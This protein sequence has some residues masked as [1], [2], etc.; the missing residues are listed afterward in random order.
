MILCWFRLFCGKKDVIP[1]FFK[2]TQLFVV[3]IYFFH[4]FYKDATLSPGYPPG[5]LMLPN[6]TNQFIELSDRDLQCEWNS[7]I[8]IKYFEHLTRNSKRT[9]NYV[10]ILY[11]KFKNSTR[12]DYFLNLQVFWHTFF[13]LEM[14]SATTLITLGNWC[15]KN[16]FFFSSFQFLIRN[17]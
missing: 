12:Q 6:L 7:D 8:L 5:Y 13:Q 1:P 4:I 11:M 14:E 3:R 17:M 15:F 16:W 10:C 9:I 2:K